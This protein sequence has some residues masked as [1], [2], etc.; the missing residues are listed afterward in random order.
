MVQGLTYE[1]RRDVSSSRAQLSARFVV[2]ATGPVTL[3]FFFGRTFLAIAAT[4][5]VDL[6]NVVIEDITGP[7]YRKRLRLRPHEAT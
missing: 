1:L 3:K 2:T 5:Q 7:V 6:D 4:P